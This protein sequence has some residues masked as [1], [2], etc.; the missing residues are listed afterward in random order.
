MEGMGSGWLY[1]PHINSWSLDRDQITDNGSLKGTKFVPRFSR[2]T[3]GPEPRTPEE[4]AH[5]FGVPIEAVRDAVHYCLHKV[6]HLAAEHYHYGWSAE[7]LMRQHADL[8][9]EE[10]YAA[11]TYFFLGGR[12]AKSVLK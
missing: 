3:V 7:E 12:Q 9:P 8:R 11:L 6:I 5:D 10:V 1:K 2:A 4:I